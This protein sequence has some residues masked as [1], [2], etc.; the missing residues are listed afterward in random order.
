VDALFGEPAMS[1]SLERLLEVLEVMDQLTGL[2][3]PRGA[4][5]VDQLQIRRSVP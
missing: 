3:A 1:R 4:L 5:I 2:S